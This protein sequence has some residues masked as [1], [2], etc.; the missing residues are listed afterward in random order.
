[1]IVLLEE[2]LKEEV[3]PPTDSV[4]CRGLFMW[5]P[6]LRQPSSITVPRQLTLLSP[7]QSPTAQGLPWGREGEVARALDT[8]N[9][10]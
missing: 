9:D 2:P 10:I 8:V 3:P 1:M 4:D 7:R 6:T 5:V